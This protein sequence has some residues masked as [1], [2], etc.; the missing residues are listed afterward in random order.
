M[1]KLASI[2][3][4]FIVALGCKG[5]EEP[6]QFSAE[7]LDDTFVTL[8]G[9]TVAFS[10][11]LEKHKGQTI[12]IDVWASWCKDCIEGMPKVKTLQDSQSQAVYVFL[13][14][15]KTQDAWKKGI[16]KYNVTGQHYFMQSGWEGPFGNFIN[17]DWIPRY[18]VVNKAGNIALYKAIE[19]DNAKLLSTIKAPTHN[20]INP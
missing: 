10:S 12:V 13:S 5:P 17:L 16:E 14:L 9:E 18:M 19:A 7:A 11:I 1:K 6:T 15:D 2:I 4:L 3:F 20:H 8:Q